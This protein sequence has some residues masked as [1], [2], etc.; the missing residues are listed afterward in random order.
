MDYLTGTRGV[1]LR[2]RVVFDDRRLV[3]DLVE[4][5]RQSWMNWQETQRCEPHRP[6]GNEQSLRTSARLDAEQHVRFRRQ[7]LTRTQSTQVQV[8]SSRLIDAKVWRGSL[9]SFKT[10]TVRGSAGHVAAH[11]HPGQEVDERHEEFSSAGNTF[12][13]KRWR[14]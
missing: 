5:Q 13:K 11:R 6:A 8:Q 12:V 14:R 1:R 7:R 2:K 3:P 4:Q 10:Q 9:A